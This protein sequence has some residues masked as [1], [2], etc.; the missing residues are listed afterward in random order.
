MQEQRIALFYTN[1][2]PILGFGKCQIDMAHGCCLE[3]FMRFP[4]ISK[5]RRGVRVGRK[6]SRAL[7]GY[8]GLGV[9]S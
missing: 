3:R 1:H 7:I 4:D 8:S 2:L 5:N 6:K 9:R